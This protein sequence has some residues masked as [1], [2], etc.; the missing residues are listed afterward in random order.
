MTRDVDRISVPTDGRGPHSVVPP[1]MDDLDDDG[2]LPSAIPLS[3]T[4]LIVGFGVIASL[5]VF[6]LGR[7]W[8]RRDR[9][10]R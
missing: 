2:P 4:Q 6:L 5:I 8:R 1:E 10:D 3:P 7:R 9:S